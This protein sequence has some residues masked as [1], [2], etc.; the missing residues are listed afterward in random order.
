MSPHFVENGRKFDKVGDK[1]TDKVT[2]KVRKTMCRV[3]R[4]MRATKRFD[5]VR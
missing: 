1:V 5:K 4:E 3:Q 2:D